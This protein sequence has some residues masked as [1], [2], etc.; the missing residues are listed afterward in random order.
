MSFAGAL[1]S[2]CP[3]VRVRDGGFFTDVTELQS[4][5][6]KTNL[7]AVEERSG[8]LDPTAADERPI[9]AAEVLELRAV[10]RY[11]D[12][13]VATGNRRRVGARPWRSSSL[14]IRIR[15]SCMS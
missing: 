7:I 13:S 10:R 4:H 12:A 14:A 6:S 15:G 8:L 2:A 11:E 3:I 9:F 1:C 5:R